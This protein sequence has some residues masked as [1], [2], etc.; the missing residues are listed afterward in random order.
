MGV[1]GESYRVRYSDRVPPPSDASKTRRAPPL[2]PVFVTAQRPLES[3]L[4]NV[5]EV[6]IVPRLVLV[7]HDCPVAP[8]GRRPT[9]DEGET[10]ARLAIGS[11]EGALFS[12]FERLKAQYSFATLLAFVIGPAARRLGELWQQDVCD[13]FEVTLGVG[14][15]QM[16]MNR[17]DAPERTSGNDLDRHALLIALPGESHILGLR[18]VGKLMDAVGWNVMLEEHRS[19]EENAQTVTEKWISVVGLTVSLAPALERAAR[20]IALIRDASMNRNLAVLVGGNAFIGHPELVAQ[21]GADVGG[22]DAPTAVVLASHLL[23]CQ[24]PS[25]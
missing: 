17:L 7:H 25:R 4:E 9:F 23:A 22:F 2:S 18:I 8:P 20:T 13:F 24:P 1:E 21:V 19:A 15:L 14:R 10:L 6:D 5:I 3:R 11:E 16:L 12:Y